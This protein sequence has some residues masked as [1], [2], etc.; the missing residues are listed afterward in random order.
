[1]HQ[2]LQTE[3]LCLARFTPSAALCFNRP[4]VIAVTDI[5]QMTVSNVRSICRLMRSALRGCS[6]H[7][8]LP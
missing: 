2:R 1:M 3:H 4:K 7:L 8:P 5:L 6:A